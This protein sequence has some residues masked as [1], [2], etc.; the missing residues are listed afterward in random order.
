MRSLKNIFTERSSYIINITT[1]FVVFY[2]NIFLLYLAKNYDSMLFDIAL[3]IFVMFISFLIMHSVRKIFDFRNIKLIGIYPVDVKAILKMIYLKRYL[4][5][6]AFYIMFSIP[7][8]IFHNLNIKSVLGLWSICNIDL[9]I[10]IVLYSFMKQRRHKESNLKLYEL[11]YFFISAEA[12][13]YS[14]RWLEQFKDKQNIVLSVSFIV[15]LCTIQMLRMKFNKIVKVIYLEG[16]HRNDKKTFE[17]IALAISSRILKKHFFCRR[18]LK[19]IIVSAEFKELL[20][21]TFII[22]V[23]ATF[24]VMSNSYDFELISDFTTI[25][26]AA[27]YFA[28]Q[29]YYRERYIYE[30]S[31]IMPVPAKT[32]IMSKT[33]VNGI[34]WFML[35][36]P[37]V[38]MNIV[39]IG[40]LPL[41]YIIFCL[42]GSFIWSY[43]G[44]YIDKKNNYKCENNKNKYSRVLVMI[45][46]VF[47]I[48]FQTELINMVG[49]KRN[50][51]PIFYCVINIILSIMIIWRMQNDKYNGSE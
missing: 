44:V 37:V 26:Y 40:G 20:V 38:I 18:E 12:L 34:I 16:N 29:T 33:V 25:I 6:A 1:Y 51:I 39:R 8:M 4:G 49:I 35:T 14:S 19:S 42:S 30:T 13:L 48:S 10:G 31:E 22:V 32:L 50:Q 2:A 47:W 5:I 15:F 46:A 7:N 21:R 11:F 9:N 28:P 45:M 41:W 17:K 27:N 23:F 3:M 36:V 24:Y 43:V